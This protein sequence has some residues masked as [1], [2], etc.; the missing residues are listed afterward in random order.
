MV[1]GLG[2]KLVVMHTPNHNTLM[3]KKKTIARM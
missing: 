2:L 3:K 1:M